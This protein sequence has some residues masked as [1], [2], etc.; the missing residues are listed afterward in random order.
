M[1]AAERVFEILDKKTQI[2]ENKYPKD[3]YLRKDKYNLKISI[4]F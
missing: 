3:N 2:I 4:F 1:A